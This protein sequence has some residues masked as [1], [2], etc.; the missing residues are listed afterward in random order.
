MSGLK[1][2]GFPT[3]LGIPEGT[4]TGGVYCGPDGSAGVPPPEG[5]EV[6]VETG[7]GAPGVGAGA[8]A[9]DVGVGAGGGGG[10]AD[11]VPTA[12]PPAAAAAIAEESEDF[13]AAEI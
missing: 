7:V 6:S 5:A 8:V 2:G 12:D 4:T 13:Q 3:E 11:E 10:G 9:L 1:F